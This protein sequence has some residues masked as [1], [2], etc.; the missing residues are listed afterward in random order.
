MKKILNKITVTGADDTTSINDLYQIQ[1]KYPFV[2]FG[3]L[4]RS[5]ET[6]KSS[7]FS[8]FPSLKWLNE[9][10]IK[11]HE[12][13]LNLSMHLC[14]DP[15]FDI[16]ENGRLP[17]H[18]SQIA[19]Q[20]I[21]INTHGEIHKYNYEKFLPELRR[22]FNT[23]FIFQLDGVNQHLMYNSAREGITN[24]S[25]LYDLSHGAGVVP[26]NWIKDPE[27]GLYY[28]YAGGLSPKNVAF[29]LSKIET[30]TNNTW[31]DAETFLRKDGKFDLN[32]VTEFLEAASPWVI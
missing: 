31:I 14:G 4:I 28:G 10:A 1:N 27:D 23:T 21:Q 3:I 17:N 25:G 6:I 30:L 9:L 18:I 24:I 16:L 15:V 13:R 11:S 20:R 2:E 29:Q 8:R 22:N 32:L 26:D 5:S 19:Y 12:Q 7:F